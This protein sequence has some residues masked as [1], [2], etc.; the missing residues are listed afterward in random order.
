[1]VIPRHLPESLQ[2]HGVSGGIRVGV[3]IRLDSNW[4]QLHIGDLSGLEVRVLLVLLSYRDSRTRLSWPGRKLIAS[5]TCACER[6]VQ[7]ALTDLER[8][9][10]IIQQRGKPRRYAFHPDIWCTPTKDR[11]GYE[12]A[13]DR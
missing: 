2:L 4:V 7:R 8:A 6:N 13:S 5:L 1:M 9:G 12:T 10:W 3:R 11:K